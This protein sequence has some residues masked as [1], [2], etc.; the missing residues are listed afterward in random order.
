VNGSN[1]DAISVAVA[2][3][4]HFGVNSIIGLKRDLVKSPD[5]ACT[6][7]DKECSAAVHGIQGSG[8]ARTRDSSVNAPGH[9][10]SFNYQ[11]QDVSFLTCCLWVVCEHAHLDRKRREEPHRQSTG[12]EWA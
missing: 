4:Y 7:I 6:N 12:N 3:E 1:I 10:T 2:F 9:W 5:F 11:R 8:A